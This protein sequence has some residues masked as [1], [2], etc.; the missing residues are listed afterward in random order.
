M[1]KELS[2]EELRKIDG[3]SSESNDVN[4]WVYENANKVIEAYMA[5]QPEEKKMESS[6]YAI[7][8]LV[9]GQCC[10]KTIQEIETYIK[11]RLNINIDDL[12]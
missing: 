2:E 7:N 11:T 1:A 10:C 4:N 9:D 3:G 8:C 5:S 6:V 12:N